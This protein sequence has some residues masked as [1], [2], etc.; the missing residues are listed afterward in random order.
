MTRPAAL[1]RVILPRVVSA[2][3]LCAIAVRAEAQG[4]RVIDFEGLTNGNMPNGYAGMTWSTGYNGW[5]IAS[6]ALFIPDAY[7]PVSGTVNAG[8]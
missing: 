8:R 4:K 7:H 6:D 1:P 2:I 5:R 3:L